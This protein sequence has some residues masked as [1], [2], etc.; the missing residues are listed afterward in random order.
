[1]A[2]KE[3][4]REALSGLPSLEHLTERVA[5]GW[6]LVAIEWEREASAAG[7]T[8]EDRG[9]EEI[10][11]GLRVSDDCTGLV[12]SQPEREIILTALDMIVE[13]CPL[14]RVA[15]ELNRRGHTTREGTPWT[16]STL[17]T[18]LP[19]MIQVGPRVFRSEE[20]VTRKKRLPRVV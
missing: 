19:R 1:M 8:H 17:F 3:R 4:I 15:D 9:V 12:E 20:W 2:Q 7:D 5:D 18:L 11:Y 13:D 10:P 6:K 14:S 16:P